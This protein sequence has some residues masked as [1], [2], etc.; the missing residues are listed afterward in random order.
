MRSIFTYRNCPYCL[1]VKLGVLLA[2]VSPCKKPLNVNVHVN[3][4]GRKM[5]GYLRSVP[6]VIID[7]PT[8]KKLFGKTYL[9]EGRRVLLGSG[10]VEFIKTMIENLLSGDEYG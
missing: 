2:G 4:Q 10:S 1:R 5:L 6:R 8:V 3:P 9:A 7:F